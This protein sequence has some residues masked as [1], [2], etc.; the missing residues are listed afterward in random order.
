MKTKVTN[1]NAEFRSNNIDSTSSEGQIYSNF[2]EGQIDSNSSEGQI[3]SNSSEGQINSTSSEGQ[4][5]SNSSEG[6]IDSTPSEGQIDQNPD[7]QINLPISNEIDIVS[8]NITPVSDG[9]ESTQST[10]QFSLNYS[11]STIPSPSTPSCSK[12]ETSLYF[13]PPFGC[14]MDATDYVFSTPTPHI[15]T[16]EKYFQILHEFIHWIKLDN[17]FIEKNPDEYRNFIQDIMEQFGLENIHNSDMVIKHLTKK[18]LKGEVKGVRVHRY[19]RG[20]TLFLDFMHLSY[21]NT[22]PNRDEYYEIAT[23]I[24]R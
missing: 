7:A 22:F 4:I 8:E 5:D 13:T 3:D 6:Q 15:Y 24:S 9:H 17:G 2:S 12:E 18:I 23:R 11:D 10:I 14:H 19:L 16:K 20:I 1:E 21:P